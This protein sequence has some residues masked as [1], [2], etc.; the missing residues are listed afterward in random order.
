MVMEESISV[1]LTRL[2]RGGEIDIQ[3]AAEIFLRELR[4]G[5]LGRVSFERVEDRV[6]EKIEEELEIGDG[7]SNA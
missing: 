1:S 6:V 4:S 5:W 3:R 2:I 7:T